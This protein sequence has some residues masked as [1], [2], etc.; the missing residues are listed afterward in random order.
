M[1]FVNYSNT[2]LPI[3]KHKRM[4]LKGKKKKIK[5]IY[6]ILNFILSGSEYFNS[7]IIIFLPAFVRRKEGARQDLKLS[8]NCCETQNSFRQA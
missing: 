1:T 6:L 4:F 5:G 8:K 2:R 7:L 3:L